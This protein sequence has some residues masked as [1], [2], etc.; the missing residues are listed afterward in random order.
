M[1][2]SGDAYD[3]IYFSLGKNGQLSQSVYDT[4]VICI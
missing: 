1:D 2:S 4:E 3:E